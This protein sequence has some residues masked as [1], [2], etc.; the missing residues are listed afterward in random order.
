MLSA[1]AWQDGW[2]RS[3]ELKSAMLAFATFHTNLD[4]QGCSSCRRLLIAEKI[5]NND[6]TFQLIREYR[7]ISYFSL[8]FFFSSSSLSIGSDSDGA[9]AELPGSEERHQH[10]LWCMQGIET[11]SLTNLKFLLTVAEATQSAALESCQTKHTSL[12]KENVLHLHAGLSTGF[13]YFPILFHSFVFASPNRA[14]WPLHLLWMHY[15]DLIWEVDKLSPPTKG[16]LSLWNEEVGRL[17]RSGADGK[18]FLFL[19]EYLSATDQTSESQL[20]RLSLDGGRANCGV[21]LLKFESFLQ[22]ECRSQRMKTDLWFLSQGQ[23]FEL[24][25]LWVSVPQNCLFL[26]CIMSEK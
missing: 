22:L 19:A 23:D 21:G 17:I 7:L 4:R 3:S 14:P 5:H 11:T 15:E 2:V 9:L 18:C 6:F 1:G 16:M 24:L 25:S 20:R 12:S 13:D 10:E 8:P 26:K